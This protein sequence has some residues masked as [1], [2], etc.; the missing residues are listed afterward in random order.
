M[1]Y[2]KKLKHYY[3]DMGFEELYSRPNS[4]GFFDDEEEKTI[5]LNDMDKVTIESLI[6]KNKITK[7]LNIDE[8]VR[9]LSIINKHIFTFVEEI[10][11]IIEDSDTEYLQEHYC[12]EL[13]ENYLGQYNSESS[14]L[15]V[16]LRS[17]I[18]RAH[19]ILDEQEILTNYTLN[20]FTSE[21]ILI[22]II[23]EALHSVIDKDENYSLN[24]ILPFDVTD[25]EDEEAEEIIV[26]KFAKKTVLND[27]Y[28][29]TLFNNDFISKYI[30][31]SDEIV[32][33]I[34]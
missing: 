25:V 9:N 28:R 14:I 16:N 2:Y 1:N 33:D 15:I 24:E 26:E 4:I 7:I 22:T 18:S 5:I 10:I 12:V 19:S 13:N 30:E 23:H 34:F 6:Y 31:E 3:Q 17:I 29:L 27:T 11:F 21:E 20:N 32:M 8:L